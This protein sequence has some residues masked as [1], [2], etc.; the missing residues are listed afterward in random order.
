MNNCHDGDGAKINAETG[1]SRCTA[2]QSWV[3]RCNIA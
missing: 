3:L 2:G 1:V